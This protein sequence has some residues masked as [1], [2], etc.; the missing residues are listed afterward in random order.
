MKNDACVLLVGVLGNVLLRVCRHVD[1]PL[2]MIKLLNQRYASNTSTA[3]TGL[4]GQVY[5]KPYSSG[6]AKSTDSSNKDNADQSTTIFGGFICSSNSSCNNKSTTS[7]QSNRKSSNLALN[8]T[9]H[10]DDPWLDSGASRTMF[11]DMEDAIRNT[12]KRGSLETIQTAVGSSRINCVGSGTYQHNNVTIRNALHVKSLNQ[13]LIS[14]GD[15]CDTGKI[16][17][18]TAKQAIIIDTPK[19]EVQNER[20]IDVVPRTPD[21]LYKYKSDGTRTL[22]GKVDKGNSAQL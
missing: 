1:S 20:I 18:F 12:Y 6:K 19:V 10:E 5:A 16:V 4:M 15:I 9:N 3:I 8:T 2:A 7:A 22:M 11:K 13:T 14:V 17:V 21:V